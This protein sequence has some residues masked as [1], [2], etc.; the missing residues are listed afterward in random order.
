M[1]KMMLVLFVSA[2]VSCGGG[3]STEPV[4]ADSAL[5]DSLPNT[6]TAVAPVDTATVVVH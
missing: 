3:Q 6:D 2:L 4:V 5:V 1:K